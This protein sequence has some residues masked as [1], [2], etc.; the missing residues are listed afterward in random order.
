MIYRRFSWVGSQI[1]NED[2]ARLYRLKQAVRIPITKLVAM[3]VREFL[4]K[5]T[6]EGGEK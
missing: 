5:K 4:D 6:S 2:M 3:A 1:S